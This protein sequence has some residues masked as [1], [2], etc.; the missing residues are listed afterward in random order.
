M[1]KILALS[2]GVGGAK[3]ALGLYRVLPLDSLTVVANTGDDFAHLGL[4]IC[5]DLDTLMY[6]L[7]G[8]NNAATGW[9]RADETW[10][11]MAALKALG[12]A[13]WF[14][15][16]DGDLATHVERRR[17]LEAGATLSGVCAEFCQRLGIRARL[18]P[19]SDQPVRTQVVT[20]EGILPFQE[21]F[22]KRRCE[23]AVQRFEFAGIDQARPQPEL[24]TLLQDPALS[25]VII[26]PSNPFI[27]VDP[28]LR[29]PGVSAAL[30]ACPAPLVAVTPIIGGA[31]VKGPTAKM[32]RELGLPNT[33]AAVAEHYAPLLNG[34]V[35]DAQDA[36]QAGQLGLPV[37]VAQTLMQ[38]LDDRVGLAREVLDFAAQLDARRGG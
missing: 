19:M 26:C 27:S 11:F 38:T 10:T 9:G 31:A 1:K 28:I 13:D 17:R 21:Y 24:L 23:P 18:L 14:A 34:Y 35:L 12:G 3:L 36:D 29:L 20:A 32:M 5:P 15:L 16:G 37:R 33:A 7:S 4:P 22:V 25:A 2:G 30:Q 6:T 8:L